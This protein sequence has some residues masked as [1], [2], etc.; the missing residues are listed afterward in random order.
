MGPEEF[1]KLATRVAVEKARRT[2]L[3][4]DSVRR[5]VGERI[6]DARKSIGMTQAELAE[7]VGKSRP[8]IV[9]LEQGRQGTTLETLVAVA[10]SLN[11]TASDLIDTS[12]LWGQS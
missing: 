10:A 5:I 7:L 3:E 1:A 8:T 2:Q 12:G 4:I 11:T 9:N 6:R